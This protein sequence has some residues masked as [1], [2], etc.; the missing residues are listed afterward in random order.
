MAEL[1]KLQQT[2]SVFYYYLKSMSLTNRSLR[3]SDEAFLNCFISGLNLD[4]RRDVVAMTPPTLLCGVA[5]AKIFEEKY[6]PVPKSTCSSYI[7]KYSQISTTSVSVSSQPKIQNKNS[8]PG[9]LP[10]PQGP[11]LKSSN[12]KKISP[13]EMQLRREKGLCY[14]CDE[15]FY[16]SHKCPN[17]QFLFLQLEDEDVE[18]SSSLVV[19]LV[20]QEVETTKPND[21]HLSLNASKGGVG[22]GTI[23]FMAYID[24]LPMTVLI[25]GGSSDNF[26]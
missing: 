19:P 22:V 10:T 13:T 15:K 20:V 16:F 9:L 25:D 8:L 12:V 26:L 6:N 24:K 3:L 4:I 7:Q 23:K 17:R 18:D 5:L 11:P 1:F 14:F 2:G 21:H